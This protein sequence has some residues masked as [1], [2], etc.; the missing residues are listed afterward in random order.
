[1]AKLVYEELT[2][3]IIGAAMEVHKVLG[4]GFLEAVYQKALEHELRLRKILF[5]AQVHLPVYYKG[6][7]VGDYIADFLIDGRIIVEIKA[8]STMNDA[9]LAQTIHYLTATNNQVGLLINFGAKSL[10][11]RRVVNTKLE[12]SA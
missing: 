6:E 1:M 2:Y 5:E 8:V 3:L 10:E 7:L 4:N 11:H 9:H 12:K